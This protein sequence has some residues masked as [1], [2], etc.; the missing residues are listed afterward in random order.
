MSNI[1]TLRKLLKEMDSAPEIV[2]RVLLEQGWVTE[3][4]RVAPDLEEVLDDAIIGAFADP[5]GE[6]D[7]LN[8]ALEV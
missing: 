8:D 5:L 3:Q 7:E 2:L 1:N 6:E 4:G